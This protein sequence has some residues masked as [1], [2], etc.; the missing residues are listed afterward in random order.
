MESLVDKLNEFIKNENNEAYIFISEDGKEYALKEVQGKEIKGTVIKRNS[1]LGKFLFGKDK[2]TELDFMEL[3]KVFNL[4]LKNVW[5]DFTYVS[6]SKFLENSEVIKLLIANNIEFSL[7]KK[8]KVYLKYLAET[9]N[10]ET[11]FKDWLL[12]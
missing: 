2:R 5:D 4:S 12:K 6:K 1:N 11:N 8:N 10:N 3:C 9:K 7:P